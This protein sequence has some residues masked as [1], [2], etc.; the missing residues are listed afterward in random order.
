MRR[1]QIECTMKKK[2]S[3][4]LEREKKEKKLILLLLALL[5]FTYLIGVM[6][7][8]YPDSVGMLILLSI[9]MF[10][11][12]IIVLIP[13]NLLARWYE[14]DGLLYWIIF[15]TIC[16]ALIMFNLSLFK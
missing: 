9:T 1:N 6:Y 16:L 12:A 2:N 14:I 3:I 11:L 15:I 8:K 10:P 7:D 4:D 5:I 13:F